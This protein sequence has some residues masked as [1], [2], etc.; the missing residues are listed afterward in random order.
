MVFLPNTRSV[1]GRRKSRLHCGDTACREDSIHRI[2]NSGQW[3]SGSQLNKGTSEFQFVLPAVVNKFSTFL[4]RHLR[5]TVN[6]KL[7]VI[8]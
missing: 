1:P 5:H 3:Q 4:Q 2:G 7:L 6:Q 8:S